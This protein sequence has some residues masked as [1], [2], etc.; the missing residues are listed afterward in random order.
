M[1]ILAHRLI[2]V[3]ITLNSYTTLGIRRTI[4]KYVWDFN[5]INTFPCPRPQ[6]G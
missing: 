1:S 2:F 5:L 3:G 6:N 4:R